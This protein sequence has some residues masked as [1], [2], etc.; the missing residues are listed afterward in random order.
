MKKR[1]LLALLAALPLGAAAQT[2]VPE[3]LL[4]TTVES[5]GIGAQVRSRMITTDSRGKVSE[6]A[7]SNFYG[8]TGIN[9][10][11]V[12]QNN[13]IITDKV[14]DLARD[15]WELLQVTSAAESSDKTAG[16]FI[17]RYIF[18]R[19]AGAK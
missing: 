16:I 10:E 19:S 15:G 4:V 8:F 7:L 18:K 13:S 14:N 17:T 6:V 5:L 1:L 12:R 9:F 2:Q 3:F 11:G